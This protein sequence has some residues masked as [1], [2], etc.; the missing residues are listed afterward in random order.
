[1][2][3]FVVKLNIAKT[4][5]INVEVNAAEGLSCEGVGSLS[6]GIKEARTGKVSPLR[7]YVLKTATQDPV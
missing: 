6:N 3:Q 2:Q 4:K 5:I 1:L 7:I